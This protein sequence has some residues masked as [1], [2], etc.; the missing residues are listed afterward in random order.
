MIPGKVTDNG[1]PVRQSR[2]RSSAGQCH[3]QWSRP[4]SGLR[5]LVPHARARGGELGAI[6]DPLRGKISTINGST[7]PLPRWPIGMNVTVTID[8]IR[9]RFRSSGS[10]WTAARG[11][12][13]IDHTG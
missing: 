9:T 8:S 12:G 10:L 2:R 1:V 4:G 6:D 3:G 11:S 7:T 13:G 5:A